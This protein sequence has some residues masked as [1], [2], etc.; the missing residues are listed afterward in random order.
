MCILLL[1]YLPHRCI[2]YVCVHS[3]NPVFECD[4]TDWKLNI[5]RSDTKK[6]V[7]QIAIKVSVHFHWSLMII[8]FLNVL[9]GLLI[10][11]CK[12]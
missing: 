2:K 1:N 10:T 3:I 6:K 9:N 8:R 7:V 4:N 12:L 5:K 11:E